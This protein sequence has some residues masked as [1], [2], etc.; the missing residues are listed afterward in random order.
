[1]PIATNVASAIVT[2][3]SI[4]AGQERRR[5]GAELI[6]ELDPAPVTAEDAWISVALAPDGS[7]IRVDLGSAAVAVTA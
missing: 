7:V 6:L 5:V 4:L 2:R 3:A 1:M